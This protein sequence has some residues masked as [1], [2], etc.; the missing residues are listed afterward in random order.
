VLAQG[1]AVE[2]PDMGPQISDQPFP[3]QRLH[4]MQP[5]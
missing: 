3:R 5:D 1:A 2:S 4:A